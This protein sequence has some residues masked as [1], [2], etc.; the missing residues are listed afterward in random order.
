[1]DDGAI[2]IPIPA[3]K[4]TSLP[5]TGPP[6]VRATRSRTDHSKISLAVPQ[7]D[8][9][10]FLE[11]DQVEDGGA[12]SRPSQVASRKRKNAASSIEQAT[13]DV[14]SKRSK[15][16]RSQKE[17]TNERERSS[18]LV[19][20]PQEPTTRT[21]R[22]RKARGA[23]KPHGEDGQAAGETTKKAKPR[24][25][26]TK[27]SVEDVA[28]EIVTEATGSGADG[29]KGGRR[30]QA[31][32]EGAESHEIATSSVTMA[33]LV[34]DTGLG[35]KSE[36]ERMLE[37]TNWDEVRRKRR[38]LEE[39]RKAESPAVPPEQQSIL[40]PGPKVVL[41][42]GNIT[43]VVGSEFVD[44]AQGGGAEEM[45]VTPINED[46]IV[47]RVT[48]ATVGRKK[49]HLGRNCWDEEMTAL[50]YRGLRMFG[51]DFMMVSQ[52]FPGI[53]RSHVKSKFVKEE[54]LNP[55]LI[56]EALLGPREEVNM[57]EF[58]QMANKV[59]DE[60]ADFE[61]ILEADR[62]EIEANIAKGEA[63]KANVDASTVQGERDEDAE[64]TVS[65]KENRFSGIAD[66]IVAAATSGGRKGKKRP[67][68]KK[69]VG[70]A[71]KL[72][73]GEARILGPINES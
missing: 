55:D 21:T 28:A 48:T 73:G 31:T 33:D 6:I 49:N 47:K 61:K 20:H 39:A 63:E 56:K 57:E 36:R 68:P 67:M 25:K 9:P 12:P 30:R 7:A 17:K 62:Q 45:S 8:A 1:M 64:G 10:T 18:D 23:D 71:R 69:N 72:E 11:S 22:G 27:K 51:T 70:R 58:S 16:S 46:D 34:K 41:V 19:E 13:T 2:A 44:T 42:N 14:S 53:S 59:Y 43:T 24:K 54:R 66:Q 29:T 5:T 60:V 40:P 37:N 32:P 3:P 52:M 35:K 15:I 50:F 65:A 26:P 38:E 4:A